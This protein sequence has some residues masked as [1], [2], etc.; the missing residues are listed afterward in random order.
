MNYITY[1]SGYKHQLSKNIR[2]RI[3]IRGYEIKTDWFSLDVDGWLEAFKGYAWDGASGPT[4]DTPSTLFP[5]LIHDIIFQCIR[6]GLLP[7]KFKKLADLILKVGLV[8]C[9]MWRFRAFLWWRGVH[10]FAGFAVDPDNVKEDISAPAFDEI[11]LKEL[12]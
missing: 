4:A 1:K 12:E 10:R 3:P 7:R 11:T 6:L 5:S 8:K 9:G 2:V